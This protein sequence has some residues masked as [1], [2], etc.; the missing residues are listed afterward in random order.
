MITKSIYYWIKWFIKKFYILKFDLSS[1]DVIFVNHI[2][3]T[4][5]KKK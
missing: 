2:K 3:S 4:K 1:T 5:D